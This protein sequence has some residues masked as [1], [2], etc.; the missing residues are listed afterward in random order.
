MFAAK[1]P[2][3]HIFPY[4]FLFFW[5]SSN[6]RNIMPVRGVTPPAG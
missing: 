5:K 6:D 1:K 2:I 4:N 3:I